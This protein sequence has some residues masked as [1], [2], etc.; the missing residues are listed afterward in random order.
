MDDMDSAITTGERNLMAQVSKLLEA[1]RVHIRIIHVR[2]T[3]HFF[4]DMIATAA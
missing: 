1:V 4:G 3:S 2:F